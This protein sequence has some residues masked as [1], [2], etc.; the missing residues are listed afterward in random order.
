MTLKSLLRFIRISASRR[1]A[2]GAA[3]LFAFGIFCTSIPS[4]AQDKKD[5]QQAVTAPHPATTLRDASFHSSS[6]SRE[7]HYRV[8]LPANYDASAQRYPTLF[9]LHGL[10]GDYLN[11]STRTSL[12]KYARNLNLIIAMPDAGNSWYVNSATDPV[13]KY[14][15]Y[16]VQ[17]FINEI[18]THY[19]TVRKG[20]ARAVAGL[21]MGGYGAVKFALKHPSLFAYA[22]GI[23]AALDA[24]GDLDM[25]HPEF[26]DGLR[27][28]FGE[29]GDPVRAKNDV[30]A[31][32][33]YAESKNLPYLYLDC[34]SDDM[35]LGVNRTFVAR[36]QQLKIPY[37]FHELPGGHEWIYWDGA[38]ERFLSML[39]RHNFTHR[40]IRARTA[41]GF[42]SRP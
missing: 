20:S 27:K 13:D 3:A 1:N 32:L 6:L 23:S 15:D 17:D 21:S 12:A 5:S 34:G 18:D 10:N 24:S 22:G 8:L 11:W 7:M 28:A 19:R 14:E 30:F 2:C 40:A 16:I 39:A 38:I 33:A 36:V 29:A 4:F 26:R 9:L 37:E 35:F 25:T 31:L 42:D 41:S